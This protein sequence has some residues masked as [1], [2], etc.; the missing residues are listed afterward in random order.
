MADDR[1]LLGR[2]V[3]VHGLDGGLRVAPESDRWPSWGQTLAR[4]YVER[5]GPEPVPVRQVGVA[6]G[7]PVLRLEGVADRTAALALVGS[8]IWRPAEDLERLPEG[9]YWWHELVGLS[10]RN[11][12]GQIVGPV[13][14]IQPGPAHDWLLVRSGTTVRWIPFVADWVE[15]VRERG[16][17]R[18]KRSEARESPD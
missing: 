12:D 15:V 18:L 16:E 14:G 3:G 8:R 7:T 6:R 17:V 4:V 5:L 2:I 11:L 9:Q 1:V 13:E 10:V